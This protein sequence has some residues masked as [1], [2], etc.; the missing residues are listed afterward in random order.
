[1]VYHLAG[2]LL[3]PGIPAEEYGRTHVSGTKLLL[4]CCGE[5]PGLERLVYCST[6]GV[7]GVT[8][9]RPADEGAPFRPTNIYELSKADGR[10]GGPEQV[11]AQASRRSSPGPG[12]STGLGTF[13][14]SAFFQAI[15]RRRFRPIGRREAWLHPIYIDDMTEALVRCG[16]AE[17]GDRRMLPP[18]REGSR[19]R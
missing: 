13:T 4:D 16:Q 6:T 3:V 9:D 19:W 7:L 8:G 17:R 10:G 12:L 14:F 5:A 1:M 11:A 15:F 18:R 2:P